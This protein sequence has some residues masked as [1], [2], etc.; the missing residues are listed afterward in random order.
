VTEQVV[1][2]QQTIEAAAPLDYATARPDTAGRFHQLDGLRA[3]AVLLVLFHH[4]IT[5]PISGALAQVGA[6][7][8]QDGTPGAAIFFY[9]SNLLY[10][11][12]AS[13]VE[14]FFVLSGIVLLRPYLRGQRAFN[15]ASYFRRR[16]Q[17]LW[18]PYL[19]ALMAA[20]LLLWVMQTWP[21]WY[22][23]TLPPPQPTF[24]WQSWLA[25]IGILNLGWDMYN[26]A[27]WSLTVE[28]I[29][30][31]V[32]P[33]LVPVFASRAM[34]R[35]LFIV[36]MVLSFIGAAALVLAYGDPLHRGRDTVQAILNFGVYLP[37]FL[38]GLAIAKYDLPR[39]IG[40]LLIVVGLAYVLLATSYTTLNVHAGY[41]LLYAGL[42]VMAFDLG[43][44]WTRFLGSPMM[45]WMG[46]RS[47]SLFLIHFTILAGATYAVAWIVPAKTA[48]Y[49]VL[50]RLIG[51]PG[52]LLA[53]MLLFHLVERHFARN[54]VT[55]KQFWPRW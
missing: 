29:F 27:W 34:T 25:Q 39:R 50:T 37:C 48:T 36:V 17:R 18:P 15:V 41:G 33:L 19:V 3:V 46:E 5:G 38:F 1:T 45:V 22:V 11:T 51:L 2:Q 54:L 49:G 32:A 53:A 20:G 24:S 35:I 47:Y 26:V 44:A 40:D 42:V 52:S 10:N 31:L 28:L 13:G 16:A 12:T 4:S 9:L 6:E 55:D 21:N 14:L 23:Q 30:Y 8:R 43:S 7:F